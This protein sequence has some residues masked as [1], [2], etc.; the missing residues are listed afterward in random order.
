MSD[1][2]YIKK[3]FDE[4]GEILY[5][6]LIDENHKRII[7]EKYREYATNYDYDF[8]ANEICEEWRNRLN[9]IGFENVDIMYSGFWSQGDGACFTTKYVDLEKFTSYLIMCSRKYDKRLHIWSLWASAKDCPFNAEISKYSGNYSHD[10]MIYSYIGTDIVDVPDPTDSMIKFMEDL[11]QETARGLSRKIYK[12]L[13]E[14]YEYMTTD[15]YI[16]EDLTND[17]ADLSRHFRLD[18]SIIK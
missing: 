18:G 11:M 9:D 16:I 7:V 13:E 14:R 10:K 3:L 17:N 5:T 6:D 8:Y 4:N 2:N 15:E 1:T 12:E